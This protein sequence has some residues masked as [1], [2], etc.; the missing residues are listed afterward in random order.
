MRGPP[1]GKGCADYEVYSPAF[2]FTTIFAP[3]EFPVTAAS[4]IISAL[5]GGWM[6][7]PLTVALVRK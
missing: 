2:P 3:F 4:Y 5:A 6:N 1:L 7:E